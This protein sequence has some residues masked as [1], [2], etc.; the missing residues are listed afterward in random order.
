MPVSDPSAF[1]ILAL[2]N[3]KGGVGKTT[4]AVNLAAAL[5]A[6][7]R[8]VLID[9]DPQGNASTGLG[10]ARAARGAGSYAMLVEGRPVA[11][12]LRPTAIPNL[13]I[14]PADPNLAGGELELVDLARRETRLRDALAKG[15]EALKGVEWVLLDCPPS[16]GLLTLNGLVAA[17]SVMV[18]L[19]AE[20][21]ALEGVS[22]I[23]QT[24]E[25][26]RA[27]FNPALRLDGIVLTM[28][29]RRNNLAEAVATD[30]RSFFKSQVYDTVIPRNVRVSEAPS[31][32]LPVTFYDPRSPGA[33][34]Y[35]RL[36]AE[37]LRRH[38]A[39]LRE[40]AKNDLERES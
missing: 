36:A 2:A 23:I 3:Q 30:V 18:P 26:V 34:A 24:L 7:H 11:E 39:R 29:D 27:G 6:R 5:A 16:L 17:E 1:R 13:S 32:G 37:F 20:F 19:Q 10:I 22:Q 4:T 8:V 33:E 28:F 40:L 38:R 25:R 15:A 9:L 14:I 31:H 21:Y 35:T 12:V